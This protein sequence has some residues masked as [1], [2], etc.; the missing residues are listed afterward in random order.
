VQICGSLCKLAASLCKLCKFT[1]LCKLTQSC[2]FYVRRNSKRPN[3]ARKSFFFGNRFTNI[4]HA[5]RKFSMW[6]P[7]FSLDL[8][9]PHKVA[10]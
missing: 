1:N 8:V 5:L 9:L 10:L 3:N 6:A 4:L 7:V 2:I